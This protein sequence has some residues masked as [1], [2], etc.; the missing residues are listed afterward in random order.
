M[1]HFNLV[2]TQIT[3]LRPKGPQNEINLV[4][5]LVERVLVERVLIGMGRS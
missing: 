1:E 4:K 3:L 5:G 2:V